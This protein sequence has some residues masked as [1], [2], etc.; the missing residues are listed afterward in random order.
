MSKTTK[1]LITAEDLT[2][3]FSCFKND[4]ERLKYMKENYGKMVENFGKNHVDC[5]K[6]RI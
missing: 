6:S 2:D 1:T 4:K 3:V 5:G